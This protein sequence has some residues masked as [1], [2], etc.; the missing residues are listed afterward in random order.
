MIWTSEIFFS[1]SIGKITE[2]IGL[3]WPSN[4]LGTF[5]DEGLLPSSQNFLI[6]GKISSLCFTQRVWFRFPACLRC[7]LV[8]DWESIVS[9][10]RIRT[11]RLK[12]SSNNETFIQFWPGFV[13]IIF[14]IS[15]DLL[16]D[17]YQTFPNFEIC[18]CKANLP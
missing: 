10:L 12:T 18:I 11:N 16:F 15:L 7:C 5:C 13:A 4:G 8:W 14:S 2:K 9:K 3:F 6:C 1:L 17:W